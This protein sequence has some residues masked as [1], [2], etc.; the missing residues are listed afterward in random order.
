M[1]WTSVFCFHTY[2]QS[3]FL[4]NS[5]WTYENR[6]LKHTLLGLKCKLLVLRAR[7][8]LLYYYESNKIR[9]DLWSYLSNQAMFCANVLEIETVCKTRFSHCDSVIWN[10][11]KIINQYTILKCRLLCCILLF[12]ALFIYCM[13]ANVAVDVYLNISK[14][15]M[16]IQ[17]LQ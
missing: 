13:T 5:W 4:P 9:I 14:T 6:K 7:S 12:T 3:Q 8:V 2:R 10:F 17:S 11:S 16:F 15:Y 1:I